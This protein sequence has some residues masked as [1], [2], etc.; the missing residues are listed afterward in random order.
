MFRLTTL[1]EICTKPQK[2]RALLGAITAF[3]NYTS[4][5]NIVWTVKTWN[6]F[7]AEHIL[8]QVDQNYIG[9][10]CFDDL[11]VVLQKLPIQVQNYYNI[12]IVHNGLTILHIINESSP[13]KNT[14]VIDMNEFREKLY[15]EYLISTLKE[16]YTQLLTGAVFG[17]LIGLSFKRL[18]R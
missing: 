17:F 2:Q 9:E 1:A 7:R 15:K 4:D 8:K 18:I 3:S 10:R 12:D 16:K 6:Q 11:R 5:E 14:L 13:L